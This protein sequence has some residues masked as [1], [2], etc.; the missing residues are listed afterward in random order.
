MAFIEIRF[1]QKISFVFE[2]RVLIVQK[3]DY[4]LRT[5]LKVKWVGCISLKAYLLIC[6]EG[7]V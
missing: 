6:S 5:Q 7:Y 4:F 2:L 3:S 1:S